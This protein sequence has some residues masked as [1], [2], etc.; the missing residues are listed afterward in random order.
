MNEYRKRAD[1]TLVGEQQLRLEFNGMAPA[2]FDRE[3]CDVLQ[4]D[5]VLPAPAP[6]VGPQHIAYRD[7]I[8]QDVLGNWIYAWSVRQKSPQEIAEQ[9][10][11]ATVS[12][13]RPYIVLLEEM[14]DRKAQE[15]RYDNRLTCA[16]RAG[17]SGPYQA[18]GQAFA[19]WMDACNT[20]TY[21]VL[22]QLKAGTLAPP[23]VDEMFSQLPELAWPD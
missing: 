13:E 20:I 6:E 22:R 3:F 5:P 7:G 9:E 10:H 14:L 11:A 23:T 17:Y 2:V 19:M 12:V 21:E 18:E 4:V 1:G 15:R 8:V 16:L